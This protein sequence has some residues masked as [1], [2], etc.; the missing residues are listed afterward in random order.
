MSECRLRSL[1]SGPLTHS[2]THFCPA[3]VLCCV[4][5]SIVLCWCYPQMVLRRRLRATLR[6][7]APY[8]FRSCRVARFTF[9]GTANAELSGRLSVHLFYRNDTIPSFLIHFHFFLVSPVYFFFL[10]E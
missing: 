1:L 6:V 5:P 9:C 8:H 2:L 10:L 3:F 7:N 4:A